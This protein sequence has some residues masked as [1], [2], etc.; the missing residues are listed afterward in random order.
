MRVAIGLITQENK[1]FILFKMYYHMNENENSL[2]TLADLVV[3]QEAVILTKDSHNNEVSLRPETG[4]PQEDS[5]SENRSEVPVPLMDPALASDQRMTPGSSISSSFSSGRNCKLS[6]SKRH[7]GYLQSQ[8]DNF[9]VKFE[10]FD[11]L[12]EASSAI[13]TDLRNKL[14]YG[15]TDELCRREIDVLMK[16]HRNIQVMLGVERNH[17]YRKLAVFLSRNSLSEPHKNLP[18]GTGQE[19][20]GEEKVGR[21]RASYQLLTQAATKYFEKHQN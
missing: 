10:F 7:L 19:E 17:Y 20:A 15:L 5:V 2:D 21:L 11:E 4:M 13:I 6:R 18:L 16:Y 1:S 9:C 3:A 14:T 12:H 8:Y